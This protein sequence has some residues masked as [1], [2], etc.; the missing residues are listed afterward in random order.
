MGMGR[1]LPGEQLLFGCAASLQAVRQ[2]KSGGEFKLPRGFRF[3]SAIGSGAKAYLGYVIESDGMIAV[4]FRGTENLFDLFTDFNWGQVPYPYWSQAGMTHR[5][6][7]E[8]YEQSV[9]PHLHETLRRLSVRKRLLMSGH[10][11]G[12]AVATLAA[13]DIAV[14]TKFR[15]LSVCTYGSPK[16]GSPE[17]AYAY[18]RTI[19]ASFRVVNTNDIVPLF[20]PSNVNI[21]YAH[22]GKRMPIAFRF[23]SPLKNHQIRGYAETLASVYPLA[24][25]FLR[26]RN[27]GFLPA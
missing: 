7:T 15:R 8:L 22:V 25:E 19:N 3:V 17:F 11:L 20:P 21:T 24:G 27:P 9:R 18:D 1:E 10:S 6:F 4:A 23:A 12:G 26:K 5:G 2:F 16:V 13:L 14:H